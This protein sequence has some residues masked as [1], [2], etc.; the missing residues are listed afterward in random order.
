MALLVLAIAAVDAY[1][2]LAQ[3][4]ARRAELEGE[5]RRAEARI[6]EL[7]GRIER[8]R[9]D[10][11]T[12]ERLAREELGLV[13]PED[14]VVVFP[15]EEPEEPEEPAETSD[16]VDPADPAGEQGVRVPSPSSPP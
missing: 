7:E 13:R 5:I 9:S 6:Q 3:Q 10:P 14:I 8:M 16:P 4:R 2:D 12:L 15:E 1:R 11:E